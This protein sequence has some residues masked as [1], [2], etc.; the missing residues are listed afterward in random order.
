MSAAAAWGRP[1]P[2]MAMFPT[3]GGED[4]SVVLEIHDETPTPPPPRGGAELRIR[5]LDGAGDRYGGAELEACRRS[6]GSGRNSRIRSLNSKSA[7]VNIPHGVV[8]GSE[9]EAVV[10]R[11]RI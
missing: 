2:G 11:P 9:P 5:S 7:T 1:R 6:S 3:L 4:G 10:I 8:A